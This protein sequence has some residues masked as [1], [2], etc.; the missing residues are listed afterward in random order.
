MSLVDKYNPTTIDQ[1]VGRSQKEVAKAL[2]ESIESGDIV[3]KVL[4]CGTSGVGKTSIS[5]MYANAL[6]GDSHAILHINCKENSSVNYIRDEIL[7]QMMLNPIFGD[8]RILFLD[9]IHGLSGDAQDALLNRLENLPSHVV[10]LAATTDPQKLKSALASRLNVKH[11]S[12]PSRKEISEFLLYVCKQEGISIEEKQVLPNA[13]VT[14]SAGV[15]SEIINRSDGNIRT[16][17]GFVEQIAR[18]YY[19]SG[20]LADEEPQIIKM[21]LSGSSKQEVFKAADKISSYDNEVVSMC[22]W[23]IKVLQSR[24]DQKLSLI[25]DIF[26]QGLSPKTQARVS[27]YHL[28]NRFYENS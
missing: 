4:F 23:A 28:L 7:P 5:R 24:N 10:I 12:I 27:F 8:Y 3:Q 26:G 2:L 25:L 22:S 11:L 16:L 19:S 1:L 21:L 9:E 18:N 6:T 15:I 13:K 14:V 17:L 20:G